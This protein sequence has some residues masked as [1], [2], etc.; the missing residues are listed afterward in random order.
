[1]K[2]ILFLTFSILFSS[3]VI[4]V[5]EGYKAAVICAKYGCGSVKWQEDNDKWLNADND[6]PYPE[7]LKDIDGNGYRDGCEAAK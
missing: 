7:E 3:S 4:A 2:V 5:G 1:M 6:E